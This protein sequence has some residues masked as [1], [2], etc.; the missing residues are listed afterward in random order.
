[1]T[2][3]SSSTPLSTPTSSS[4]PSLTTTF[5]TSSSQT[6]TYGKTFTSLLYLGKRGIEVMKLQEFLAQDKSIYPEGLVTGY[7]G[8]I[9]QKAVQRF[10]CKYNI[11]CYGSPKT[12]GFGV[13]GPKTRSKLNELISR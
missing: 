8:L 2:P 9:T 6:L 11:I 1:L 5:S 10:Q 13:V 12:T 7:F 4:T 3:T